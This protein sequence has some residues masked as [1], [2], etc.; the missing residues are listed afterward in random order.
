MKAETINN[1]GLKHRVKPKAVLI[2]DGLPGDWR[3][4]QHP[5]S[6]RLYTKKN[7]RSLGSLADSQS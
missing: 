5:K 3:S 7:Q 6:F 4:G 2:E 1:S